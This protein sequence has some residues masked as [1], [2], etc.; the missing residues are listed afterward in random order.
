ME[1]EG[2]EQETV[3]LLAVGGA[4]NVFGVLG[5]I[6]RHLRDIAGHL[7]EIRLVCPQRSGVGTN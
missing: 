3:Q 5:W 7:G 1:G 2:G 4:G 6:D